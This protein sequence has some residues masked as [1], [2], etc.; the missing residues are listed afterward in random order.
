MSRLSLARTVGVVTGVY[1]DRGRTRALELTVTLTT[2]AG[3]ARGIGRSAV[4]GFAAA[5]AKT[6]YA[7]DLNDKH[8][9]SLI[10]LVKSSGYDSQIVPYKLDITDGKAVEA[11]VKEII[12]TDG[13][14]DWFASRRAL[15]PAGF[16]SL[17]SCILWYS[18]PTPGSPTLKSSLRPTQR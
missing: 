8:F 3:T 16:H 4:V 11:L 18:L 15:V 6:I 2:G 13:R 9:D 12:K 14:L 7:C 10:E 1:H 5:G 17:T